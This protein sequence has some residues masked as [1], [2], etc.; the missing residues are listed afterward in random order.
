MCLGLIFFTLADSKVGTKLSPIKVSKSNFLTFQLSPSFDMTGV[1][2]I[3]LALVADAVIGNVQE[4]T[5]K[6]YNAS[7]SEVA[8]IVVIVHNT[9]TFTFQV[10][11]FSYSIGFVYLFFL[12]AVFTDIAS[13]INYCSY[14]PKQTY[15]YAFIFS[16]T[17]YL[18]IQVEQKLPNYSWKM[19][20]L[21]RLF[22]AS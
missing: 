19:R 16:L 2:M 14:Y 6:Q 9:S 12:V 10:V 18:G 3:S 17:G 4:K 22:S 5:I 1:L 8:E 21:F 11:L 13:A 7:N 15:G 20:E